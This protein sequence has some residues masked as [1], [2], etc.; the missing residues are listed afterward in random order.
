MIGNWNKADFGIDFEGD[1]SAEVVYKDQTRLRVY[2]GTDG[3]ILASVPTSSGT[4]YENPVIA[5]VDRDGNAE[6]IIASNN[7]A[8]PLRTGIQVFEDA[9]D[10]WVNTRRIWNQHSYAITH[11][12]EN[13]T[14]PT[15]VTPHWSLGSAYNSYRA[16]PPSDGVAPDLVGLS[17]SQNGAD[18]GCGGAEEDDSLQLRFLVSNRGEV[19][20]GAEIEAAFEGRWGGEWRALEDGAGAL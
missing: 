19:Q 1:G 14:I 10:L 15:E 4:T 16:Q 6:I 13:G 11:V 18:G 12:Q 5:D 7:Y 2:R 3:T 8:Y 9:A 20:V 17:L